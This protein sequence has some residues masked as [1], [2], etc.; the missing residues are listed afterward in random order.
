MMT[1]GLPL[2]CLAAPHV[3]CVE[4]PGSLL[5]LLQRAHDLRLGVLASTHAFSFALDSR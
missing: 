2:M 1:F 5:N 3:Y 4:K